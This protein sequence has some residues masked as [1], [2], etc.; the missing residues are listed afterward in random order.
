MLSSKK[1]EN[2][3]ID[4][5]KYEYAHGHLADSPD[6]DCGWINSS[7]ANM[8]NNDAPPK[9]VTGYAA[10]PTNSHDASPFK[11]TLEI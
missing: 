8:G 5:P 1:F 4:V 6:D 10:S 7:L 3:Y 9:I 11:H 2:L